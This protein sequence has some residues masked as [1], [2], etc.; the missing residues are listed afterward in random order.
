MRCAMN[1]WLIGSTEQAPQ[2][3][4]SMILVEDTIEDGGQTLIYYFAWYKA[5]NE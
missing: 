4:A 1:S 5:V 2:I 3:G